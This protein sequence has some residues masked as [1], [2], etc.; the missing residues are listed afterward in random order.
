MNPLLQIRDSLA[1]L[2]TSDARHLSQ[3]LNLPRPLVQAMLEQLVI[4]HKAEKLPDKEP[5]L[6]GGC[7]HCPEGKKCQNPPRYRLT[8]Q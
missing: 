3:R 8:S 5:A 6:A 4:M 1:L 2:G 7:Q